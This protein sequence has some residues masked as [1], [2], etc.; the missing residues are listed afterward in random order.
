METQSRPSSQAQRGYP[1]HKGITAELVVEAALELT[2][3]RGFD[4]WSVR[5]LAGRLGVATSA[6]YH[7][8]GGREVVTRRVVQSLVAGFER[9]PA[10]LPWQQW[11]EQTLLRIRQG[12]QDYPGV[13]HWLLLHG[14]S[15]P[16]ATDIV[17]A[18]IGAL[19]RAG[20]GNRAAYAYSL[21][22]NL[23]VGTIVLSDD[24]R[25]A[26]VDSGLGAMLSTF[27]ALTPQSHGL[28]VISEHLLGPMVPADHGDDDFRAA[29]YLATIR[30]TVRGLEAELALGLDRPGA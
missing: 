27:S 2:R 18:G 25:L 1:V 6:I 22:F 28:A 8:V 26:T 24:R 13:A 11:F 7:H 4:G 15:M 17:D 12:L 21:L 16:E 10:D 30:T 9:A 19:E 23:A 20:F 29:H 5:E 14:P 3:E